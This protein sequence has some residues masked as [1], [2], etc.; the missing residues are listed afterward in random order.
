MWLG[1]DLG[2]LHMLFAYDGPINFQFRKFTKITALCLVVTKKESSLNIHSNMVIIIGK[3]SFTRPSP[4][5]KK[6][7][8]LVGLTCSLSQI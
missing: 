2:L 1:E 7:E 3:K 5:K 8:V 6:G 4:I